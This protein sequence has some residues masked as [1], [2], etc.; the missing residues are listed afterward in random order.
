MAAYF[1]VTEDEATK[2]LYGGGV[3]TPAAFKSVRQGAFFKLF[4]SINDAAILGALRA[5]TKEAVQAAH[6]QTTWYVF[7]IDPTEKQWVDMWQATG[8]AIQ[9]MRSGGAIMTGPCIQWA[10]SYD[11]WQVFLAP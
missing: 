2:T 6:S 8:P 9:A 5:R 7:K 10:P 11:H 1:A 3:V 4:R